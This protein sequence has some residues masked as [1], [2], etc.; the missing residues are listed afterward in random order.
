VDRDGDGSPG[1]RDDILAVHGA[2][3]RGMATAFNF[4]SPAPPYYIAYNGAGRSCNRNN[5]A[6]SRLGTLSVFD[7][8]QARRIKINMLGRARICD[9]ARDS[10]CDGP[11]AP[12]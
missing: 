6:A 4:T 2:L 9:P 8:A 11:A 3:E 7:G 1:A 10:T 12:P 5:S